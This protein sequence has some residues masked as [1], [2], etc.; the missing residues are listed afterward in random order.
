M[1]M[2]FEEAYFLEKLFVIISVIRGLMPKIN[3]KYQ[4][5]TH[6]NARFWR[7]NKYL[8]DQGIDIRKPIY[9]IFLQ[10]II[11]A[12]GHKEEEN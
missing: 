6:A 7:S 11:I 3:P 8:K 10:A 1:I 5:P 9:K 4:Q 12:S 2:L